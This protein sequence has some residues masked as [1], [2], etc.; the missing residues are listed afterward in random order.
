MAQQLRT[1]G[2]DQFK[3]LKAGELF[4]MS[5]PFTPWELATTYPTMYIGKANRPRAEPYFEDIL[6]GNT[7]D[8][9]YLYNPRSLEEAP[10]LFVPTVQFEHFLRI[11]NALAGIRLTIPPGAPG[12]KFHLK[13]GE[14]GS[15]RPRFLGRSICESDFTNIRLK[16]PIHHDDDVGKGVSEAVIDDLVRKLHVLKFA[17]KEAKKEKNAKRREEANMRRLDG[18]RSVQRMLGL[19]PVAGVSARQVDI[20][21]VIPHDR[22]LDA[23]F[24]AVDI[25]VAEESH[26]VILEVGISILDTREVVNVPPGINAQNWS[27][28]IEYHHLLVETPR[29]GELTGRVRA[30][31]AQY[32]AAP[33]SN[34]MQRNRTLILVGHDIAADLNYLQDIDVNPGQ[35]PGFLGCADTKDMHQA[36]R[37][38]PSGCNLGAV[39]GDLEIPTRNLHNAGNDAAYT[40]QAMLAL[41]VRARIDEQQLEDGENSEAVTDM[42]DKRVDF[43]EKF[44]E[45]RS[46]RW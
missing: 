2:F 20:E 6:E 30:L 28:L 40:L 42:A 1:E 12:S 19:R 43:A 24:A 46:E 38:C 29:L 16:T 3:G 31:L 27:S 26:S 11:V 23:V 36:W 13:F 10:K 18:I 8:F 25:E 22:E 39:C 5:L 21:Q 33:A 35:L 9:F 14:G 15:P 44:H 34:P 17:K 37:S 7:W 4:A 41:A 45:G 32:T